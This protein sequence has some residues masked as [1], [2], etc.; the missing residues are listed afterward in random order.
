MKLWLGQYDMKLWL[1]QYDMS[2]SA[3]HH[4]YKKN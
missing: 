1:G 2:I 4:D 3:I